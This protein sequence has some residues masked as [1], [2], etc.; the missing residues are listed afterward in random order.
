MP[1]RP[2]IVTS[3]PAIAD[4][5]ASVLGG[6]PTSPYLLSEQD[7]PF[8]PLLTPTQVTGPSESGH[9]WLAPLSDLMALRVS[10]EDAESF[11]QGQLTNDLAALAEGAVQRTGLCSPK[12]RLLG[13]FIATRLNGDFVLVLSSALTESLHKRLAMFV[14]RAKVNIENISQASPALGLVC[15]TSAMP[16]AWPNPMQAINDEQ[17]RLMIGIESIEIAG[18]SHRRVIALTPSDCLLEDLTRYESDGFALAPT[19][20]WHT[21][22]VLA[23]TPRIGVPTSDAFVPQMINFELVGGVSFQKGCFPGQEVVARTQYLGKLK[24]RLQTGWI[25]AH[26]SAEVGAEILDSNDSPV[27][28]VVLIG[29]GEAVGQADRLFVLFETRLAALEDGKPLRLGSA[30]ITVTSLPYEI[31]IAERFERPDL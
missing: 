16:S 18:A 11:L 20:W 25:G 27:G 1:P 17:N 12:G 22:E 6:S 15:A 2:A 9:G 19:I 8:G 28:T 29:P 3:A 31:P 5:W 14:L 26:D 23:G 10:G 30:A 7:G 21:T 24:R 4:I 13:D